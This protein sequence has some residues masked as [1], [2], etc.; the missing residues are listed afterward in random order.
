MKGHVRRRGAT[1]CCVYDEGTDENGRRKQRW[2][3]GF[4]TKRE[5]QNAL[6]DVLSR[7][8][9]G[10]YVLPS[11]LTVGEYLPAWVDGLALS[12]AELTVATY[13]RVVRRQVIPSLGWMPLQR[14]TTADLNAL[15]AKLSAGGLA[16][17]TVRLVHNVVHKALEAAV[18]QQLVVRNV[19]GYADRPKI[20]RVPRR[21]W[22]ARELR[23][24]LDA[25]TTD[26][27][28]AAYLFAATTG[29]RRGEVLGLRWFDVN[30]AGGRAAIVQT[31][32]P[33][34][35]KRWTFSTTK[36]GQGRRIAL[37]STTVRALEAHRERQMAER[38]E[39]AEG[40]VD[41]DLVFARENGEPLD[42]NGFSE[43][44]AAAL[45]RA[46]M[47]PIRLHDLRHTHATLAL[48]AGIHPKIVSERLGHSSVKITLDL[49]S[50]ATPVLEETA[51]ELVAALVFADE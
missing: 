47:P 37:D 31:V 51:A 25:T 7:L 22:S 12:K 11:R 28:Y 29:A 50:H 42:P 16:P 24:F 20:P 48:A 13:R 26:R 39:W 27:L 5:A 44:F 23:Q 4:R 30:L 32:I 38:A 35:G 33:T 3:G 49:Y 46:K 8:G 21:T 17:S 18:R 40:Y 34:G 15:Y 10:E 6:T 14:V 45:K 1:W 43:V 9:R 19:A 36:T 41:H 2:L